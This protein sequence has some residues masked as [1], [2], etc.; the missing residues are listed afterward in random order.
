MGAMCGWVG[1]LLRIDLSTGNITTEDTS[2]YVPEYI[3]GKGVCT[4]IA[5]NELKPGTGPYDADNL[6]I[7]I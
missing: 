7:F 4:R 6:L 2:Q 5:W 3:G 1:K